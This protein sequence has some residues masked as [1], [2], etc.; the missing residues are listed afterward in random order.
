MNITY[1]SQGDYNLPNLT[2]PEQDKTI[3]GIWGERRRRYLKQCHK[4]LYYILL[5]S[6]K[7]HKHLAYVNKQ[8]TEMYD[9]LVKQLTEQENVTE[10]LKAENQ[11]LWVQKMN[12]I[13]M[14]A[15]ELINC[16]LIYT[17]EYYES[18]K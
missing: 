16:E 9:R 5:T 1:S 7:L 8:A 10:K 12:S 17:D 2:L 6:C 18:M 13:C 11:M 14:R 15:K 3:I 4:V